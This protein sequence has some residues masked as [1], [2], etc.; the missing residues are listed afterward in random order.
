MKKIFSFLAAVLFAG[1]MMASD[2][3]ITADNCGWGTTAGELSGTVSGVTVAVSNGV[4]GTTTAE[5]STMRVYKDATLTI[6]ASENITKIVFNCVANNTTKYGP[7]CFG[8]QEGYS[9]DAKVGTWE[10]SAT[11]VSFTASSAQ[12]RAT[13]IVVTLAEGGETPVEPTIDQLGSDGCLQAR[14]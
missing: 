9:Y 7:G 6:S 11:S 13:S 8:A 2:V 10:G 3:T 14:C 4:T 12:V 5:G 1:S